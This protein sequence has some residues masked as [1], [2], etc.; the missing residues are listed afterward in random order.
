MDAHAI[1]QLGIPGYTL[2][3]RAGEA[4]FEQLGEGWPDARE[5][6]VLCGAGNNAG[7]GYVLARLALHAGLSVTV[8]ALS[9]PAALRG[10][11][12][13]A[14]RDFTAA[15][16]RHRPFDPAL[17]RAA[18]LVVGDHARVRADAELRHQGLELR[19]RGQEVGRRDAAGLLRFET[20]APPAG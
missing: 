4:A 5:L 9:D 10:D 11:A 3:C 7:D 18:P 13:Q 16:G 14:W 6:L 20:A 2:M 1:G 19:R 17:L 15:G 12:A 8:A